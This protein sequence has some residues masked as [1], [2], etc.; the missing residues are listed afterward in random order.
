MSRPTR[1][2]ETAAGAGVTEAGAS[3]ER[4]TE[5]AQAEDVLLRVRDLRTW[6]PIRQGL[7][8][9]VVGH[10][11]AVAGVSFDVRAGPALAP[12]GESG[13]GTATVG[14]RPLRLVPLPGAA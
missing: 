10:V 13:C 8:R 7:L 12:G 11:R 14:R 3:A 5:G 9:K 2:E 1:R 4:G 6:F